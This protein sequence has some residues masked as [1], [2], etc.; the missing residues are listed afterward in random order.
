MILTK[1]LAAYK[2]QTLALN[3]SD[4]PRN[5]PPRKVKPDWWDENVEKLRKTSRRLFNNARTTKL[6]SSWEDYKVS[7]QKRDTKKR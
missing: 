3:I 6:D 4:P 2:L 1:L 5:P 7:L